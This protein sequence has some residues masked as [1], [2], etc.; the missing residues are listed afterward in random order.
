MRSLRS[1]HNTGGVARALDERALQLGEEGLNECRYLDEHRRQGAEDRCLDS[2]GVRRGLCS[3]T[4]ERASKRHDKR[5]Y[6]VLLCALDEVAYSVCGLLPLFVA[7]CCETRNDDG[8]EGRDTLGEAE[9]RNV[10]AR[11]SGA[12]NGTAQWHDKRLELVL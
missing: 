12:L 4:D 7:A 8:D 1:H 5:L 3:D 11:T 2:R 6:G 10:S 9:S